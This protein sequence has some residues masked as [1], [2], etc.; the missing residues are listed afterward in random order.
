MSDM[1][2]YI[3]RYDI[4]KYKY[5][6]CIYMRDITVYHFDL[7]KNTHLTLELDNLR[8]VALEDW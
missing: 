7:A 1:N 3:K 6:K 5:D 4:R 2:I 8:M